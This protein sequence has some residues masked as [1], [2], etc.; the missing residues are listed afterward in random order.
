MA[1]LMRAGLVADLYGRRRYGRISSTAAAFVSAA[2]AV[3]PFAAAA[4]ALLPGGYLTMLWVLAGASV[5]AAVSGARA[6]ADAGVT[7]RPRAGAA[8]QPR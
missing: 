1:T 4:A 7:D 3:A 8:G 5:M 6:V 2:R